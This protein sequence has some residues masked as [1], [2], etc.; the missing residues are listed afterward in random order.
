MKHI[1]YLF[2][3]SINSK[4]FIHLLFSLI[5]STQSTI[6]VR[7]QAVRLLYVIIST[8][9]Y[10]A[11]SPEGPTYDILTSMLFS[12]IP[13]IVQLLCVAKHVRCSRYISFQ[14]VPP[15]VQCSII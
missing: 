3:V 8:N 2:F 15:A 6:L 13:Y 10:Y 11:C 9:I 1:K 12:I 7:L 4:L 5:D 14:T